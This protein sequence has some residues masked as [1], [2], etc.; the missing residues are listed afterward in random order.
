[1]AWI[2]F[3]FFREYFGSA[4]LRKFY[5]AWFSVFLPPYTQEKNHLDN[6]GME[7]CLP[8]QQVS[9]LSIMPLPHGLHN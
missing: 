6:A 1:M 4:R 2:V 3:S 5:R 9:T 7:L 8:A